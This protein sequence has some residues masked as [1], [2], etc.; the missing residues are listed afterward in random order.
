MAILLLQSL[1]LALVARLVLPLPGLCD[2]YA[3]VNLVED[4]VA[5]LLLVEA[6]L[7]VLEPLA[8][9]VVVQLQFL[10]DLAVGELV[11]EAGLDQVEHPLLHV[12]GEGIVVDLLV[13]Q[14]FLC[15]VLLL[16]NQLR[17]GLGAGSAL[18]GLLQ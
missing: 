5:A 15:L 13:D 12:R 2:G 18:R 6:R 3:L 4:L 8:Q 7:H 1:D 17:E 14:V 9:L 11:L 16:V 10:D